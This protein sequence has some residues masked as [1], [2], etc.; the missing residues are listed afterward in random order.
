MKRCLK[1]K[2]LDVKAVISLMGDITLVVNL[3]RA[4]YRQLLE[5]IHTGSIPVTVM[6]CAVQNL[7]TLSC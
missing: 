5:Q 1:A 7:L 4:L 3:Q 6:A 2:V